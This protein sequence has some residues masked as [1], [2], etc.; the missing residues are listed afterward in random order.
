MSTA[1][2]L[3]LNADER[4]QA[5]KALNK[6]K[7]NENETSISRALK[8]DSFSETWGFMSRVALRAEKLNHHPEW[9]NVWIF[10]CELLMQVYNRV[11][12]TLTT[13]SAGGLSRKDVTLA[14]FIDSI[15]GNAEEATDENCGC[16]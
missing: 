3:L 12:I 16:S 14:E 6:W 10:D 5:I 8:F 2:N 13:H 4:A 11:D 7:P 1:K 15:S 9:K